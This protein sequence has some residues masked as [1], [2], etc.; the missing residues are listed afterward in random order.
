MAT[1]MGVIFLFWQQQ[2]GNV[3]AIGA[4]AQAPEPAALLL[5]TVGMMVIGLKR[6][7]LPQE[8]GNG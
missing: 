1:W 6:R 3:P 7:N 2:F 8:R 5:A 4:A